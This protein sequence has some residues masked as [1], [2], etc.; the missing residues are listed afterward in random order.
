MYTRSW[1]LIAIKWK[2]KANVTVLDLLLFKIL[3]N[4]YK[5]SKIRRGKVANKGKV[6]NKKM[7]G[8]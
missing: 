4:S 3:Y 1:V 8:S 6:V 2:L 5:I 7:E